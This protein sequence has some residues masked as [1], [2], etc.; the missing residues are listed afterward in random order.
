MSYTYMGQKMNN[1]LIGVGLL[2]IA[3]SA[4]SGCRRE[5]VSAMADSTGGDTSTAIPEI[6]EVESD[7]RQVSDWRSYLDANRRIPHFASHLG[8]KI[9]RIGDPEQRMKLFRRFS[10]IAF[11]Y[12]LDATDP[13]T[14]DWQFFAFCEMSYTV[15]TCAYHRDDQENYWDV[16]LDRLKRIKEERQRVEAFFGRKG[17]V[18]K[19]KGDR[20]S[21]REYLGRVRGEY[22][23]CDRDLSDGFG[24]M[25][26]AL[27]LTYERWL[28]IR[29]QLEEELGHKVEVWGSVLERW[30]KMQKV[31]SAPD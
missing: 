20:D 25:K 2:V 11:S 6:I 1:K 3:F 23:K 29:S 24:V 26:T 30:K 9:N 22:N 27:S 8:G 19:F 28:S 18:S 14:R 10:E 17:E 21:W 5:S 7:L 4:F 16:N 15:A 12:P 13:D 31:E